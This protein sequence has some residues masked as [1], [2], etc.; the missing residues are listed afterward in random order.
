MNTFSVREVIGFGWQT[1]KKRPWLFIT[2]TVLI[3]IVNALVSG[4]FPG[5]NWTQE[6][7]LEASPSHIF[8]SI[9]GFVFQIFV[10]MGT[11]TFY[12]KAH[13]DVAL[14]KL[15]DLW[16]PEKFVNFG[17]LS[18]ILIVILPIAFILLIIPGIILSLMFQFAPYLVIDK[19][20]GPIE[21]LK[22]S[23]RIT[24]GYK[25]RLL[26]FNI[27]LFGVLILGAVCLIVGLLAA[28]PVTYLAIAHVYRT[29]T[30]KAEALALN[31]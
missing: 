18:L 2:V 21:A 12:I 11:I 1:F 30:S 28:I 20:M 10:G 8:G 25:W 9:V 29:L 19:G 27:T 4:A 3:T 7:G 22:E 24:N 26:G 31:V 13:D 5:V 15:A 23:A 16:Q 17:L 14:A 6:T